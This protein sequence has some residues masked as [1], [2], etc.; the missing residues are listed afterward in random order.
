MGVGV[1]GAEAGAVGEGAADQVLRIWL[2]SIRQMAEATLDVVTVASSAIVS[3]QV[4]NVAGP[5][6][7]L[8]RW[9]G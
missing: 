2:G 8:L 7:K 5:V 4:Q 1:A 9:D 3:P 6:E